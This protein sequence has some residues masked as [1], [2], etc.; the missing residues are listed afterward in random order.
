MGSAKAIIEL[1]PIVGIQKARHL[2]CFDKVASVIVAAA[3]KVRHQ[4]PDRRCIRRA[5]DGA[6]CEFLVVK[7]ELVIDQR[8]LRCVI[9]TRCVAYFMQAFRS[10]SQK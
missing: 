5:L 8:A 3:G 10:G 7:T 2:Y 1:A 9:S 6:R 4:T